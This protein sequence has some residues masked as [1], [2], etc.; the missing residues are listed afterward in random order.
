MKVKEDKIS[1]PS[2]NKNDNKEIYVNTYENPEKIDTFL[3]EISYQNWEEEIKSMDNL[4][5]VE[6][7]ILKFPMKKTYK[8]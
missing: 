1:S 7:L 5:A 6:F 2:Y 8:H 4:I 3:Q